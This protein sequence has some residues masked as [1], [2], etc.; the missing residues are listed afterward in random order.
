[1][2]SVLSDLLLENLQINVNKK[3]LHSTAMKWN[4]SADLT[5]FQQFS[6]SQIN[7]FNLVNKRSMSETIASRYRQHQQGKSRA[8]E[9]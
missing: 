5:Q 2:I 4:K 9:K 8:G 6:W 7:R 1:M 3:T